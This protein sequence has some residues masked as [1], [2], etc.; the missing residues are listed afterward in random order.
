MNFVIQEEP[1]GLADAIALCHPVVGKRPF[2]LYMPDGFYWGDPDLLPRLLNLFDK[3]CKT[4]LGIYSI[5]PE[6]ACLYG[7]LY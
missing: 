1:T 7:S 3:T 4:S 5:T 6:K 2:L